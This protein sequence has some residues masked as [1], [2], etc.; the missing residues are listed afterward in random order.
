MDRRW[1]AL[2]IIATTGA[3]AGCD[4][5]PTQVTTRQ[6]G[7]QGPSRDAVAP[8]FAIDLGTPAGGTRAN[9]R[10]LNDLGVAIGEFDDVTT[11]YH[12]VWVSQDGAQMN[13]G[14]QLW[15]DGLMGAV[16]AIDDAGEIAGQ[17][18]PA[19]GQ[20]LVPFV[21]EPGGTIVDLPIPGGSTGWAYAL[22]SAGDAAGQFTSSGHVHA[23]FWKKGG[24]LVDLG[25]MG[26]DLS[27]A[28][29][30]NDKDEV[31]GYFALADNSEHGFYWSAATGM[32]DAGGG[33]LE[34][35]ND[36][37]VAVG[38]HNGNGSVGIT[39]TLAG[40]VRPIAL[41][42]GI[43]YALPFTINDDGV[44]GGWCGE[45]QVSRACAG[46][47]DGGVFYVS[48]EGEQQS[49]ILTIND[50]DVAL[51]SL[52]MPD[53]GVH[54]VEWQL[55]PPGAD[56]SPAVSMGGPYAGHAGSALA[57]SWS[58]T[59][60]D[61]DPLT[62]TWD[63]GDGTTGSG[64]TLPTS[65]TFAAKGTYTLTLTADDGRGRKDTQSAS[66]T[67]GD[68]L[69]TTAPVITPTISGTLGQNGWYTSNVAL[70]WSESDPE[71][72]VAS[73]S[74]CG[75][76]TVSGNTAGASFTCSATNGVGLT[77]SRTATIR[78]D[79]SAP[80]VTPTVSG[81]MG[82]NGWYTSTVTV[83]WSVAANGP[84][85]ATPSAGCATAS[86]G[87]DTPGTTLQCTETTGAG[88]SRTGTVSVKRDA[89]APTI[90]Y[91]GNV[92][93]YTVDQT[94]AITCTASDAMSGIASST[95]ANITGDAYRFAL[96]TN[97]YS[98]TAK[99]NAGNAAQA[100]TSFDVQVTAASLSNLTQR[101]VT[102]AGVANS[103]CSKLAAAAAGNA[104]ALQ[105]Y[106]QEVQAQSGKKIPADEAAILLQ[107]AGAL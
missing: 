67:I 6:V 30:L 62:Y 84:S 24:D 50:Q 99:D 75:A 91:A 26:G 9:E 81:T 15:P 97:S 90:A 69:D 29:S 107:L 48:E 105:A 57:L 51:G 95:C 63:F 87:S 60:A 92:G 86:I 46:T 53:G 42:A 82:L 73:T 43:S 74:G 66:V 31:V 89:T 85:G 34:D 8:G 3:L 47:V 16:F 21:A 40:G 49:F 52:K 96:G 44:W 103:L 10:A 101:W 54:V 102:N 68:P 71:S 64:T 12:R 18:Q 72:G 88:R 37:G 59:D 5:A 22:N 35:I 39:W 104:G 61:D 4:R 25:T 93:T 58:A 83:A 36:D 23:A 77:A 76:A 28:M 32:V 45:G 94:V 27:T 65:H 38:Y 13:S 19:A 14:P 1:R 17:R 11:G 33:V 79:D 55:T 98:A 78:R 7:L 106:I 41:P 56:H 20:L 100:S 2:A 80:T 70:T